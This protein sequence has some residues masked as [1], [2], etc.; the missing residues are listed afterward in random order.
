MVETLPESLPSVMYIIS[1]L[2]VGGAEK[3]LL[4]LASERKK[5]GA[6]VIVVS[7]KKNGALRSQFQSNGIDVYDLGINRSIPNP[8]TLIRLVRL[9]NKYKPKIIHSW[10][11]HADLLAT[12]AL[13]MSRRKNLTSL[14]WSVRCSNM[15][16]SRYSI[17]LRCVVWCCIKMSGIPNCIT[18]NS[19]AGA[20]IHQSLGYKNR[21]LKVIGNGVNTELFKP[22]SLMRKKNRELLNIP[23]NAFVI[24]NIA[25]VDPM[26][27]HKNLLLALDKLPEVY[28]IFIGLGTE[29]FNLGSQMYGLG[30]RSDINTLLATS[31]LIVSCSAFGEGSSNAL[32]EGMACGLPA[33]AT[34]IG[35]SAYIMG[36]AGKIVEARN[37]EKLSSAIQE[38]LLMPESEIKSY[39]IAARERMIK[40]FSLNQLVE[41]YEQLYLSII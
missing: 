29:Q 40:M 38:F 32:M 27:D 28:T 4:L 34:D 35:D 26:K 11:Y 17:M 12:I 14:V 21:Y 22:N 24:I 33:V 25:R 31:D 37:P 6:D 30:R 2:D 8:L 20:E 19:F 15:D 7:L 18:F 13:S 1:S 41:N 16:F 3:Q 5:K 9:I 39:K 23:S 10:M 36:K